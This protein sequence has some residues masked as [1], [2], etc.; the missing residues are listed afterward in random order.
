MPAEPDESPTPGSPP[1]QRPDEPEPPVL[2]DVSR[3]ELDIGWGDEPGER[4]E[5]WY[6]R[7]RPPHHGD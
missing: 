3:D 6:R 5:E 7:E 1:P 2:P 4:D